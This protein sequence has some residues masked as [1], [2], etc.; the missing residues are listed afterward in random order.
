M[1]AAPSSRGEKLEQR[2]E[3]GLFATRWLLAPIYFGLVA[4]LAIILYKFFE[5]LWHLLTHLGDPKFAEADSLMVA[6][7][8]LVDIALLA[9][10]ILIVIFAG[11]ENFVSRL[12]VADDHIDK[13]AWMGHVDFSGLKIKLI[14]SL[15]AISAILLLKDF[16]NIGNKEVDVDYTAIRWQIIIHLTF[17]FSGLIFAIMD[18]W[19]AKRLKVLSDLHAPDVAASATEPFDPHAS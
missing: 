14:G 13:P 19:G 11:Y 9:N 18:Y 5:Q 16:V 10:L 15:V 17:V 8:T 6:I 2:L 3:S 4:A 7:L 12:S 1:S